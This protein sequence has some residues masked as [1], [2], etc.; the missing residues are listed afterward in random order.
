MKKHNKPNTTNFG[1]G[2]RDMRLA[3]K[4]ALSRAG[5]SFSTVAT[6]AQRFGHFVSFVK[7]MHNIKQME[8]IT[9]SKVLEYAKHLTEK[10]SS[11]EL[12]PATAQNYLSAVNTVLSLARGDNALKV[13]PVSEGGL[14]SRTSVTRI[15]KSI[16]LEDH[17]LALTKASE[18]LQIL[19][20]LQRE[21]GLRFE[22][23][24]KINAQ[25]AYQQA[26][27]HSRVTIVAGTKGGKVRDIGIVNEQQTKALLVAAKYQIAH[28]QKSMIPNNMSYKQFR[29]NA[30]NEAK[31]LNINF[32]SERHAYALARYQ[33]LTGIVA[34]VIL[35]LT[36]P[37]Q[38]ISYFANVMRISYRDAQQKDYEARLRIAVDLG[39]E[40]TS[41]SR[42]YLG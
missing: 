37:S 27:K 9:R 40:R 5:K 20:V 23:S 8:Q 22:E 41:I 10:L 26:I 19:L 33:A 17:H 14:A 30:Y 42:A 21:F 39:H 2:S 4:N 7:T 28:R 32:H 18:I 1:L 12:S 35:G 24:A 36:K 31:S 38:H 25:V 3:A 13:K 6:T 34:P 16:S 29:E 15:D 11:G